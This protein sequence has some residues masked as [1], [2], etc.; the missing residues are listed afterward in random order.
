MSQLRGAQATVTPEAV[1]LRV[2]VAGLGSR[3]IA[4]I[5]DTLIQLAILIPVLIGFLGGGLGGTAE[6]VVLAILVFSI[7]WLY[8]PM[9]ELLWSG[10]TPGKR[11]QKIRVVRTDGQPAGFAPV[12]V[13]NL[14]RLVDVFLF[15]FLAVISMLV[16]ARAQR[17]GDLAAGTLVIRERALPTPQPSEPWEGAVGESV[18]GLDVSRLTEREYGLIRSFLAR[19]STLEPAA[20]EQLAARLAASVRERLGG[21]YADTGLGDEQWLQAVVRSYRARFAREERRPS[22]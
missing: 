15:P 18:P 9:F 20:R 14:V 21:G 6:S 3:S 8:F 10:Q 4:W 17:L 13:R 1:R 22:P 2:D 5:L 19:R 7:L 11:A 16:T 12:M